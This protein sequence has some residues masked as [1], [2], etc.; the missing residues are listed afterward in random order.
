MDEL[1]SINEALAWLKEFTIFDLFNAAKVKKI[2]I[3]W[4]PGYEGA[5]LVECAD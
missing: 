3:L 5:M 1:I 2:N 4:W